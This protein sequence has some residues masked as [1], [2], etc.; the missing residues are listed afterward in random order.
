MSTLLLA[1]LGVILLGTFVRLF[2]LQILAIIQ[3]IQVLF[4]ITAL[5]IISASVWSIGVM[6]DRVDVWRSFIFFFV[7][8]TV[9]VMVLYGILSDI[10][11][12]GIEFIRN[13]FKIS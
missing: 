1:I 10:I 6:N 8:Y 7:L 2:W 5:S 13:I 11:D 9:I 12:L 4:Y 3:I